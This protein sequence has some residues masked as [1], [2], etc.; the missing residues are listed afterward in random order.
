ML[1]MRRQLLC[2]VCSVLLGIGLLGFVGLGRQL[3]RSQHFIM[4]R[5][6]MGVGRS[7]NVLLRIFISGWVFRVLVI[8]VLVVE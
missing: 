6:L 7:M 3:I 5:Y 2:L 4:M 8:G 1:L